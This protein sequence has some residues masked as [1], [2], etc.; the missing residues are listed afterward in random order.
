MATRRTFLKKTSLAAMA[1]SFPS[2]AIHASTDP[3]KSNI[4]SQPKISL[5]QWSLHKALE[6]GEMKAI[7]FISIAKN[8]YG[9]NAVEYVNQFYVEHA[10]DEKF[11][12]QMR[13]TADSEAVDSLLIMVDNEGEL[14]NANNT[15]R[16]KAVENHYKWINA[17]KLLGCHSIRVNAFGKGNLE[18]LK[19][20][21]VDGIGKLTA[22]G[23]KEGINVLIENH[24]LHTSDGAFITGIIKEVNNPYLGTLPDF[25]NWCLNREWGSTQNNKCNFTYDRYKGVGE[26]L[27]YAKGVSAK[28]YDFDTEGNETIMDYPRLLQM[29]KNSNFDGH[30][31]I[32][33]EGERLSEHEG[34]LAT[35]MLIEKVWNGLD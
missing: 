35:K 20:S 21:L 10:T 4:I 1:V 34:I 25:G 22:Y 2:V 24:G 11:W 7:D 26:F 17:A 14:G 29:V 28:S 8:T 33:Y 19:S 13:S 6:N 3:S 5:A 16:H 9:I 31:G 27:P 12:N 30:I 23:E 32:E 15:A 18:T